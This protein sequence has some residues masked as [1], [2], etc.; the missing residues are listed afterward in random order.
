[1]SGGTGLAARRAA[2]RAIAEVVDQRRMLAD[3]ALPAEMPGAEKARA[4]AIANVKAYLRTVFR[5]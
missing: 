5:D 2:L 3:V 1:M 4:Q